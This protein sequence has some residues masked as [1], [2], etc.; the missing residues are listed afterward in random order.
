MEEHIHEKGRLLEIKQKG[1]MGEE[2]PL[3]NLGRVMKS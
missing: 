1:T 2:V 3:A